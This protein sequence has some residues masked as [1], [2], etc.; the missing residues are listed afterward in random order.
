[1][2]ALVL[3]ALSASVFAAEPLLAG[4]AGAEAAVITRSDASWT[5]TVRGR[6]VAIAPVQ[7]EADR[8]ALRALV[9][10]LLAELDL[11]ATSG[12][13]NAS[14]LRA[15]ALLGRLPPAPVAP[16]PAAPQSSV[17][18]PTARR[19][20][21][22]QPSSTALQVASVQQVAPVQVA[23]VQVAPVQVAS[24][25]QSSSAQG[26]LAQESLAA[27]ASPE[28][29]G[30][31]K[32][33]SPVGQGS[34]EAQGEAKQGAPSPGPQ[35]DAPKGSPSQQASTASSQPQA[36]LAA[37]PSPLPHKPSLPTPHASSALQATPLPSSAPKSAADETELLAPSTTA[38]ASPHE[39][40]VLPPTPGIRSDRHGY[41]VWAGPDLV[42]RS[43]AAPGAGLALGF[44]PYERSGVSARLGLRPSRSL[45]VGPQT[46][47]GEL[48][49]DVLY[50]YGSPWIWGS[51]GA[52]LALRRYTTD[53]DTVAL[54]AVPRS[55]AGLTVSAPAG[56]WRPGLA[57]FAECDLAQTEMGWL[58]PTA[59]FS[60]IALRFEIKLSHISKKIEPGSSPPTHED[61]P[62]KRG[63]R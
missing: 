33:D 39:H 51:V 38:P 19:G 50:L 53:G 41:M 10:S 48:T 63:V 45:D 8:I 30:E 47:F 14:A 62:S 26:S 9:T 58:E 27:Q 12:G 7:T 61:E 60:P 21:T 43:T 59:L 46:G 23:P 11:A 31:A 29:Q 36:P 44:E 37:P 4:L 42:F 15:L 55:S 16:R 40:T 49:A 25:Q 34:S 57:L 18:D 1:M 32:Q 20:S 22:V 52:G 56:R 3:L 24:A 28:A 35:V 54:H 2:S 17:V 6:S 5:V 13:S